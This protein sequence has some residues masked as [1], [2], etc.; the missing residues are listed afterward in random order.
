M[1]L[2]ICD[3]CLKSGILC[4]GC[5]DKLKSGEVTELELEISKVLYKLAEGKLGFKRA[6]DMGDVVIIITDRDQVGK[7][8][9]KGGKI[10]RTISRAI[11]KRVRV[12]GED[13]DLK[14]VAEDVLAPARISGINI[15]YG[16]DGKE[17]FKIRVIKEDARRIPASLDVLNKIIKRLTGEDTTIVV[18]EY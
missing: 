18:D 4:Q 8:I 17:K 12:V 7:L 16:K 14:S 2:P 3:V 6:I 15:V 13:S 1:G 11:G 5:E 9:G 10:V